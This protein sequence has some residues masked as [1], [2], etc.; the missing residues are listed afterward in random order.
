MLWDPIKKGLM[1]DV[2][3]YT[4][5]K[6]PT[7]QTIKLQRGVATSTVNVLAVACIPKGTGF[8][9]GMSVDILKWLQ[10]GSTYGSSSKFQ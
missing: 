8:Y 1:V 5:S 2:Y 10:D 4:T 6:G 9:E 7:E 3:L